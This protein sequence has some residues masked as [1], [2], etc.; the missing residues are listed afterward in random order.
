MTRPSNIDPLEAS[1]WYNKGVSLY[2]LDLYEESI[3]CY[4]ESI[5]IDPCYL[6]FWY[7]K[8]LALKKLGRYEDAIKCYD[9]AIE[10][11]PDDSAGLV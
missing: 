8:G 4:D 2:N 10:L 11:N 5:E 3:E 1:A 9:K 6:G 7:N